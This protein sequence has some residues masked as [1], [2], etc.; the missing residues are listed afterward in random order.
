MFMTEHSYG[1]RIV[2]LV[3]PVGIPEKVAAV[4][5]GGTSLSKCL[6]T[7]KLRPADE[8]VKKFILK[9]APLWGTAKVWRLRFTESAAR[10]LL[11]RGLFA[12]CGGAPYIYGEV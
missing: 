6:A 5:T 3:Y 2:H 7:I 8:A 4:A 1:V 9:L 11:L 10:T 12:A